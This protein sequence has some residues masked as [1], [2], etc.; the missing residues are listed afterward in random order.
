MSTSRRSGQYNRMAHTSLVAGRSGA[1]WPSRWP[2][3]YGSQGQKVALLAL[4]D[5]NLPEV[6]PAI[7][8]EEPLLLVAFAAYHGVAVSEEFLRGLSSADRL[9]YVSRLA[10]EAGTLA[11]ILMRVTSKPA[12]ASSS[13]M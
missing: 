9:P 3:D 6:M 7:T 1:W 13:P 2:L 10:V 8:Y 4:I 5:T 11:S 12:S